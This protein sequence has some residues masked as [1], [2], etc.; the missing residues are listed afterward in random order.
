[1]S[2]QYSLS[3]KTGTQSGLLL[4]PS[5][6]PPSD[7]SVMLAKRRSRDMGTA[8][9][10]VLCMVLVTRTK[11]ECQNGR[12]GFVDGNSAPS[13][14]RGQTDR[15]DTLIVA[16]AMS[17]HA[18]GRLLFCQLRLDRFFLHFVSLVC[19][20]FSSAVYVPITRRGI[21]L[22]SAIRCCHCGSERF[23]VT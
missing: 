5:R 16:T 15:T 4:L 23:V 7:A 22:H 1:V 6:P 11:S 14:F 21:D 2:H 13:N 3:D 9:I 8:D 20:L 18:G 17:A 10:I 12:T 19:P